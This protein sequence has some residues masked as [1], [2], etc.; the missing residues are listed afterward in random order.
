MKNIIKLGL[1]AVVFFFAASCENTEL[2]LLDNP[3][4]VTPDNAEL[5]L[6]FNQMVIDFGSFAYNTS[7]ETM[8]YT[9]MIAMSTGN[10]YNNQDAPTSFDNEWRLAYSRMLPDMELILQLAGDAG[11]PIHAGITNIMKAYTLFTLVDMWGDVP[12]TEALQGVENPSPAADDDQAVYNEALALLDAGIAELA[13]AND[14]TPKPAND[15][16]YNGDF[17]KWITLANTLKIRYY[18]S[19]RLVDAAGATSGINSIVDA[20]DIIDEATED[21]AY[22][23][24]SNRVNPD[25]RHPLYSDGYEVNGPSIYLNN[26]YMWTFFATGD[27]ENED[28][29][30]RYYFYRQDCDE[31]G[32]DQFTLDCVTAPYPFHWPNGYPFCTASLD[33]GDPDDNYSGYWGRDHGNNDGIPPDDLKRS[34]MGLYPIGGKFDADDCEDVS[35][36]G[37]D[38]GL[39]AGI[40]PIMLSSFTHFLLAEAALTLGTA[41]DPAALLETGIRQSIAKAQ[42]FSS[43]ADVDETL[44]ADVDAYVA[45]VLEDYAAAN[46]DEKLNIIMT[47]YHKALWGQ[48]LEAYNNYRR[49]GKPEAMQPTRDADFGTFARLMWYPSVYVN[50][51]AKADQRSIDQ[52]VFWDTNPA[53]FI[54]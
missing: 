49:T 12:F 17:N 31:T 44:V 3:N 15:I 35:N 24:G 40:Q 20:G 11:S 47:E 27:R 25:S 38:G 7:F 30:L 22:Q 53:G 2:D 54:E 39:G 1:I 32:E 9:R 51:N 21:F 28:P 33:F 14:D 43:L 8:P 13:K 45:E 4:E 10:Q 52:Q 19:T 26:Y 6:L 23:Y 48:G 18:V 29:R 5:D 41:G 37:T 42:S 50:L 46:D 34:A 16:F 36:A